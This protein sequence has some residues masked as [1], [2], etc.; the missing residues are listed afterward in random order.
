MLIQNYEIFWAPTKQGQTLNTTLTLAPVK[1]LENGVIECNH[2]CQFLVIADHRTSL[3][4]EVSVLQSWPHNL[5]RKHHYKKVQEDSS[6]MHYWKGGQK[7][8][9]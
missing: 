1:N 4:S 3:Q 2:M 5:Q 9:A 6:N 8:G 7:K